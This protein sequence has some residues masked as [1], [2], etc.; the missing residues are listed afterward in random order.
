MN[1]AHLRFGWITYT[2]VTEKTTTHFKLR[3]DRFIGQVLPEPPRQA[4][5]HLISVFGADTQISAIGAAIPLGDSFT[6]EAR[7]VAPIRVSFEKRAESYKGTLQLSGRKKPLRH[8]VAIS[9]EL[10]TNSG[11]N[12]GRT[13]LAG[14]NPG[15]LWTSLARIHGLP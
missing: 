10:A 3:L 5:A 2:K 8:L 7:N 1:N 13:L 14:R 15:F 6:V 11:A 12:V 4:K 9:E